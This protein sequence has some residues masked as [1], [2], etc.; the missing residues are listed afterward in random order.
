MGDVLLFPLRTKRPLQQSTDSCASKSKSTRLAIGR[1][2][3][4]PFTL[5]IDALYV[6]VVALHFPK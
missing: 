4:K 6:Q 3:D 1:M 2:F 5:T